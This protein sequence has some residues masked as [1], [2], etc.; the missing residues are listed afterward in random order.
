MS[1]NGI[2]Y[3]YPM[4]G[5]AAQKAEK[6]AGSGT[7]GFMETVL[8]KAAQNNAVDHDEKAFEMVGPHAPQKVKA[9]WLIAR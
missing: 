8:E 2:G 3:A 5:Y 1:V 4:A 9:R 6:S 7:A